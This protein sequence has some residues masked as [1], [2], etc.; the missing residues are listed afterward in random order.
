ML[1][2]NWLKDELDI[3]NLIVLDEIEFYEFRITETEVEA[4]DLLSREYYLDV[5][6]QK[7]IRLDST[8]SDDSE[9]CRLGLVF[10]LMT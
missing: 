3:E 5:L 10:P 1:F 9:D 7:V 6:V 2:V 8:F 4:R